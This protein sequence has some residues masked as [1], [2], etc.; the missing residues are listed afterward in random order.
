MHLLFILT[1]LPYPASRSGI[2]LINFELLK[3]AP[4]G[5]FIDILVTGIPESRDTIA[6]LRAVAPAINRINFTGEPLS[7]LYRIGNLL[8]GALLGHNAFTQT[9]VRHYLQNLS[10]TPDAIYVAPLMTGVDFR[11][12]Q[13]LF[14]NAVDSFARLN[15][16]AYQ[17]TGRWRD[18]LK[19]RLYTA[20]EARTLAAASVV[21][22]VSDAD[23]AT[24]R[25]SAPLL[26]LINLSNGV[27][28]AVFSPNDSERISGRLLFTGNFDY[29]PN[30]EAA[31]HLALDV[32]PKILAAHPSSTLQIVGRNPPK[33]VIG[34]PAII[35]TGYVEDIAAYYR[36][37]QIFVCPLL[38]GAGVKNKVLEALSSGLP[39]ITTSLGVDG[40]HHLEPGRHY[41]LA[42]DADAIARRVITTLQ[43]SG[44]RTSLGT[45][46]RA[47]VIRHHAWA[48]IVE[49]YFDALHR[50]AADHRQ[51]A[52]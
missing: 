13:P 22:F 38:S 37:A 7:R 50:V 30:A 43:D 6:Q 29:A 33:E 9:G 28:S 15:L 39:V 44:L 46:A 27:D 2:A 21:N 52:S 20:Y 1:E 16:N 25:E 24:V 36:S 32:F 14:L 10:P 18:K 51:R 45:E 8:S 19:A 41:L 49:R 3:K 5:T 40:I 12:V 31:R 34:R 17:R 4:S 35:V 47:V 26:P 23:L 11:L 48:P 42:D